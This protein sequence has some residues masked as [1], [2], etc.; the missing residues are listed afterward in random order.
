MPPKLIKCSSDN[1]L[2]SYASDGSNAG[3]NF[4]LHDRPFYVTA[5]RA[6]IKVISEEI[7]PAFLLY[8]LRNMSTDYEFAWANKAGKG[9]IS[10]KN[11]LVSV[12]LNEDGKGDLDMQRKIIDTYEKI[13]LLIQHIS[14]MN[15]ELKL[16]DM[17]IM[18]R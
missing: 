14:D 11:V 1:I 4:V 12:P 8:A 6:V 7:H 5:N 13:T 10:D 15:E 2:F 18:M 16:M 17:D 3:S 9:H